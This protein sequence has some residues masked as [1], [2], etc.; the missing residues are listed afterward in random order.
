MRRTA[1]LGLLFLSAGCAGAAAA[2][3]APAPR[4]AVAVPAAARKEPAP[5]PEPKALPAMNATLTPYARWVE[6]RVGPI[7]A[8]PFDDRRVAQELAAP[9][10]ARFEQALAATAQLSKAAEPVHEAYF[11]ALSCEADKCAPSEAKERRVRAVF[12]KQSER[13]QAA[14]AKAVAAFEKQLEKAPTAALALAVARL[15]D[16]SNR[17][18]D[19]VVMNHPAE[20]S[21]VYGELYADAD[22]QSALAIAPLERARDLSPADTEL[23]RLA[24]YSLMLHRWQG[25]ESAAA[26]SETEAFLAHAPADLGFELHVRHGILLGA[27]GRHADAARA[28]ARAL[29]QPEASKE[30]VSR[31]QLREAMLVAEYRAGRFREA[32]TLALAELDRVLTSARPFAV[33]Y[34]REPE[35]RIAAD[36]VERLGIDVEELAA[37]AETRALILS[38]LSLRAAHRHDDRGASRLAERAVT[39]S[40]KGAADAYDVL[41][42]LAKR[43]HDVARVAELEAQKKAARPRQSSF[44]LLALFGQKKAAP[45]FDERAA[46]ADDAKADAKRN[47]ASLVR[48]CLEPSHWRLPE[49][50]GKSLAELDAVVKDDG[51]VSVSVSGDAPPEVSECLRTMGPKLLA[52]APSSIHARIDLSH[53]RESGLFADSALGGLIGDTSAVLGTGGLGGLGLRGTGIGGGGRGEVTGVGAT[54][55]LGT[56]GHGGGTAVGTGRG[57]L[58]K[59]PTAKKPGAKAKQP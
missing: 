53:A 23:G 55:G 36:I 20:A 14:H 22:R 32:L 26:L 46:L 6:V 24:R 37:G 45:E 57:A 21:L 27:Q 10:R 41:I 1:S 2:P 28:F 17:Q 50:G 35:T 51:S 18:S 9:W 19:I 13:I 44:G 25:G 54:G 33:T 58:K 52:R 31:F 12:E 3:S 42:A 29:A 4:A 39:L 49:R 40:P 11:Q 8:R 47:V 15:H 38:E 7:A 34:V 56:R 5:P 59:P 30:P 48:L 16:E 43:K